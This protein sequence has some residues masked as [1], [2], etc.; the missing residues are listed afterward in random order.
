MASGAWAEQERRRA[1]FYKGVA[2][3]GRSKEY[4]KCRSGRRALE[5][6]GELCRAGTRCYE[7]KEDKFAP[8]S[9]R[10][11]SIVRA[12]A[13]VSQSEP[14]VVCRVKPALRAAA[15]R[16]SEEE[17]EGTFLNLPRC[18]NAREVLIRGDGSTA[19]FSPG[20]CPSNSTANSP[21]VVFC[22]FACLN[23]R[24]TSGV[25]YSNSFPSRGLAL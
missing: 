20:K 4:S 24:S 16:K 6:G 18:Q 2:K 14:S 7:G 25:G 8:Y 10:P 5:N 17:E 22:V 12:P 19:P 9:P 3:S 21:V 23:K 15:R 1:A 11:P 13:G